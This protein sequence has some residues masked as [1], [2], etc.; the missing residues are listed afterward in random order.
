MDER[1]SRD[2]LRERLRS[3]RTAVI[4]GSG[5]AFVAAL[6]LV[7]ANPQGT[8]AA[9]GASTPGGA[10]QSTDAGGSAATNSSP[11]TNAPADQPP[12]LHSRRS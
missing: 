9:N 7:A 10:P 4:W 8:Q 3:L 11:V 1:P 5:I 12:L 6:G 2:E